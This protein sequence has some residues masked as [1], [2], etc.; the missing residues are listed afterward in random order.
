VETAIDQMVREFLEFPYLHRVEH[1]LHTRLAAF[2]SARSLLSSFVPVGD[3]LTVTQLVHKE[4]PETRPRMDRGNRR[5]NFDLAVL[6]PVQLRRCPN[7]LH[8]RQGRVAAPIVIEIGLDYDYQHL[9]G[10][11]AKLLNSDVPHGYLIHLVREAPRDPRAEQLILGLQGKIRAAYAV[12]AGRQR[13]VKFLN[14]TQITEP[15]V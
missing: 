12:V 10:D 14:D 9:A 13:F 7:L 8:F 15:T 3:G 1:S 6:S 2:L 11:H 4:W 5:G